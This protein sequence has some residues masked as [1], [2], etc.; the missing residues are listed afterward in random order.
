LISIGKR[1]LT[2]QRIDLLRSGKASIV[3]GIT[4]IA[5]NIGMMVADAAVL[6][7]LHKQVAAILKGVGV[8]VGVVLILVGLIAI[9]GRAQDEVWRHWKS[10]QR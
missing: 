3:L 4:L 1:T 5:G 8:N 10:G 2:G 9:L 7:A 6:R